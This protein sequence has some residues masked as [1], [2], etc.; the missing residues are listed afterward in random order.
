MPSTSCSLPAN[1]NRGVWRMRSSVRQA[2]RHSNAT[3]TIVADR[4]TGPLV[5]AERDRAAPD[6]GAVVFIL[7][8]ARAGQSHRRRGDRPTRLNRALSNG[9]A[10]S[11][12]F[13]T[14]PPAS[15]LDCRVS[16]SSQRHS[17]VGRSAV[18]TY[19]FGSG[20]DLHGPHAFNRIQGALHPSRRPLLSEAASTA[21]TML[22]VGERPEM[23]RRAG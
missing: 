5:C 21:G 4:P 22:A 20:N 18:V 11:A 8:P 13:V 16:S 14:R 23:S 15:P 3:K 9:W 2:R 6:S 17:W 19:A 12:A 1:A 7:V 10:A